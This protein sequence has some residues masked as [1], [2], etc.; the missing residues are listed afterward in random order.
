MQTLHVMFGSG[1]LMGCKH[2]AVWPE[3]LSVCFKSNVQSYYEN[4]FIISSM[5]KTFWSHFLC[6]LACGWWSD[7]YVQMGDFWRSLCR[8]CDLSL[9]SATDWTTFS[10]SMSRS[11]SRRRTAS[12][13]WLCPQT[14]AFTDFHMR[15]KTLPEHFICFEPFWNGVTVNISGVW[16]W[17]GLQCLFGTFLFHV[18]PDSRGDDSDG[19]LSLGNSFIPSWARILLNTTTRHISTDTPVRRDAL[20][21]SKLT[22]FPP[23]CN[24]EG[25][26][27][28]LLL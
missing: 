23:C 20:E 12:N 19:N 17:C 26:S 18:S 16:R 7:V 21:I 8:L 6:L 4:F 24:W 14:Q 25:Q 1:C 5:E 9:L 13:V 11:F 27:R 28:S 2:S 3:I 22:W 15:F 10:S